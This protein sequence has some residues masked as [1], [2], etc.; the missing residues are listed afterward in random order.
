M[1]W[2]KKVNGMLGLTAH[3]QGRSKVMLALNMAFVGSTLECY[4]KF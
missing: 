1:L 2:P 3:K 4:I